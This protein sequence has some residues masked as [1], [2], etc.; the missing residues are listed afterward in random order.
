MNPVNL[1]TH[2]KK[3]ENH[4]TNGLVSI[5]QLSK[6]QDKRFVH[7]FFKNKKTL[8]LDVQR[9]IDTFKVLK[10]INGTADA[11]LSNDDICCQLETKIVSY[12]IEERQIQSHL[13]Y[14]EQ[15]SQNIKKLVLLTPDDPGSNDVKQFTQRDS[16]NILHLEWKKVYTFFHDYAKDHQGLLS[17]IIRQYSEK[18]RDEILKKDY[19]GVIFTIAFNEVTEVREDTYQDEMRNGQWTDWKTPGKCKELDGKHRKLLL[20]DPVKKAITVEVEINKV[21]KTDEGGGFPYSNKFAPGSLDVYQ[22]PIA[23]ENIRKIER[24]ER[25]G[26]GQKVYRNL[27]HEQYK[28]LREFI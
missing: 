26:I 18:I 20:Y 4:F 5:L 19:V 16:N 6:F 1:F 2:Y 13:D 8:S 22:N 9:D 3:K 28:Q 17:E 23:L 10:G 14:L 24:F 15:S 21:E 25:F 12:A 11:E 27:T 7:D